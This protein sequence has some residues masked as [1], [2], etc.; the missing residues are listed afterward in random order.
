MI[1]GGFVNN[2]Y[3]QQTFEIGTRVSYSLFA[4]EAMLV[5]CKSECECN[6]ICCKCMNKYNYK[7]CTITTSA[8]DVYL[9]Y[10]VNNSVLMMYVE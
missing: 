5:M 3:K 10:A 7:G 4:L 1:L 6:K 2:I 9:S 8:R